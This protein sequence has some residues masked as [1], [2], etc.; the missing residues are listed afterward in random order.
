LVCPVT[1]AAAAAIAAT[2]DVDMLGFI[3]TQL[4]IQE[5]FFFASR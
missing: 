3:I 2:V 5:I 1:A 4:Q